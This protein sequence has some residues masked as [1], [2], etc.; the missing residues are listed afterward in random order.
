M[1][2]PNDQY[3]NAIKK[4]REIARERQLYFSHNKSSQQKFLEQ[5]LD[6]DKYGF[7]KIADVACGGGA[8]SY[9]LNNKF[10]DVEFTLVDLNDQLLDQARKLNKDDNFFFVQEDIYNLKSLPGDYFDLTCCWQTF[11]CLEHP[12]KA[13][14][15]LLRITRK[16]GR[17]YLSSLFNRNCD[18]DVYSK[19]FDW[20]RD[21]CTD[22]HYYMYNTYSLFTMNN[23]L[24]GKADEVKLY[25]FEIDVDLNER[26]RGLGTYTI[27]LENG[28]RLQIP[29]G[30]L[31]NWGILKIVK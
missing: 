30:M 21:S 29:A 6:S 4:D 28:C 18:V 12:Q 7:S 3:I 17:I 19:I 24:K 8:L 11:F 31:L 9:W 13:L 1:S 25:D 5:L 16:G 22:G 15:E 26:P 10:D 27:K 23:W 14:S 2:V 20:T